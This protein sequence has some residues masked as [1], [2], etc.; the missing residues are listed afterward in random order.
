MESILGNT[1]KPDVI[2][3]ASG[4]FDITASVAKQLNLKCGDVVDIML[5]KGEFYLYVKQR[6]PVNGRHNATVRPTN[7][8]GQHF[9][10]SSNRLCA[11]MLRECGAKDIARLGVG[12]TEDHIVHDTIIPIITK[13]LL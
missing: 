6:A 8:R 4:R 5:D 10:G 7:S 13:K 9:R 12:Q 1:R 3:R 2:F 11:A